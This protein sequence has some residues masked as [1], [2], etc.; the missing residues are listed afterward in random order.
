V[1]IAIIAILASMLLPALSK[2][3]TKAHA[4]K[5]LSNL[6]QIGLANYM[7]FSDEGKP[8]AYDQWPDLWMR[9]LM[10]RYD[11]IK[12]TRYCPT[13]PERSATQLRRDS[14]AEGWA[15]RAWLVAGSPTNYQGS[16]AL[17]G[18]LYTDDPYTAN[19]KD[20]R[21]AAESD[22]YQP[23]KT[24]FF[25]D[26]IWVDAWPEMTD[27]PARN[28]FDGDKFSGGGLSR[29][30]IPRHSF[31]AGSAPRAFNAKDQ[32]PGAINVSFADNHVELVR[33]EKLWDLTWHR[34]WE[35]PSKRP[36]R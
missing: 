23:S 21:Y 20:K 2:A 8:V 24:P 6:K 4:I 31:S 19:N 16:Y 30:A 32:L 3:K 1:V 5:C 36:G 12:E 13:A 26:A 17:N 29:I 33:L 9:R 28:L 15:T 35:A 25:A 27:R 7:Y 22:V 11:A 14:S 34:K 18:W 10:V